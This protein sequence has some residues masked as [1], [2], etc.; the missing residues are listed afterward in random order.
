MKIAN[1]TELRNIYGFP[2]ERAEKKVF[3]RLDKHSAL[4]IEKSP[5][6]VLSTFDKNGKVDTSPRGGAPG[7]V[8][9]LNEQEIIIPDSKGNNRLDSLSN[10]VETG[11]VGLLFFLPGVDESLRLNG[12]AYITTDP[13][14][15]NRFPLE[16]NPP[17]TC[18]IVTVEETFLHCA[19]AFMRS[20]LWS[21]ETQIERSEFPSMGQM[22]KDQLGLQGEVESQEDMIKRYQKD[23]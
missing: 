3:D 13:K 14:I 10:I 22:I 11:Q 8:Q 7:F 20:K 16:K 9:I 1:S 19:K 21:P 23:L 12:T 17:K 15:L 2:S 18:I 5:F 6:L 4:F